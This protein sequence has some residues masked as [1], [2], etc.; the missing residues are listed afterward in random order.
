MLIRCLYLVFKIFVFL[1]KIDYPSF[2]FPPILSCLVPFTIVI[3]RSKNTYY[4]RQIIR[5]KKVLKNNNMIEKLICE[6]I[7]LFILILFIRLN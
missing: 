7:F 6:I 3:K 4:S 2:I 5:V 1:M